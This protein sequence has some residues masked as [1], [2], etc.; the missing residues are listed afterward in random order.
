MNMN[1][2]QMLWGSCLCPLALSLAQAQ[3]PAP[4]QLPDI[5]VTGERISRHQ[6]DTSTSVDVFDWRR[7]R[8]GSNANMASDALK[9]TV[10]TVDI[11]TGN[12]LPTI[13]GID[14]S[15]PAQGAVAFLAGTRP[16]LSLSL[17]GRS[18][19]YN[20]FAFGSQSLWDIKQVEVFRGPQ[21][22]NQGKNAIAGAIFLTSNDPTDE[23]EGAVKFGMGNQSSSQT[24]AMISGPVVQDELS[25]RLSVDRQK[26]KS[27]V[28]LISYDPVGDP[29]R[30]ETT[31]TRAKLLFTPTA[32]PDFY[33][34]LTLNHI[35]ARAP[36]N[37]ALSNPIS[38]RYAAERPVFKTGSTSGIWD[39]S[40]R[41]NPLLWFENKLIYT[42]YD[43]DRLS[44]PAEVGGGPATVDGREL[45]IEPMLRF[46][47]QNQALKGMIGMHYFT[48]KQDEAVAL[49][50]GPMVFNNVFD[51]KTRTKAVLAEVTYAALPTLDVT[52]AGRLERETHQRHGGS[53]ALTMALDKTTT[54]F[55]P[56]LD[57]A[58]KPSEQ[59]ILGLRATRGYNPGGAGL[60]FAQ[61]IVSYAYEAEYVWNYELYHRYR[62][63]GR[64]FELSSNLFYNDYKDMQLP[65][66]L[67]A[68]SVAIRN[69]DKVETYGAELTG[70]WQATT[71]LRLMASLGLLKTEIKRYANQDIEGKALSRAP[72]VTMNT[73][74]AY[75]FGNGWDVAGDL[76]LVG[77]YYSDY[78]NNPVG[79]IGTY[80]QMNLTGG[81]HFKSGRIALYAD[82]VFDSG[83]PIFMPVLTRAEAQVQRPRAVGVTAEYWF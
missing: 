74:L 72:N 34:R 46:S 2:H 66:Y 35:K 49:R 27:F 39:V 64:R 22:L 37:E 15:G 33:S 57:V 53:R 1:K 45:Q 41:L 30:I 29:R 17:D 20:E 79:R 40:W 62:D 80:T 6:F 5:V 55:L 21:S 26:R 59:T 7:L 82:N 38:G 67:G 9:M 8:N 11:G 77:H 31:T 48:G 54:V 3:V 19:T 56:R 69:A 16:R 42:R 23:F 51:D 13:R 12:D 65:Y 14:G 36:Q 44:V 70:N 32:F 61:P 28:D 18:A 63:E 4:A 81:Y 60:T 47:S 83:K 52:L 76:R 24:A 10:N 25:F 50:F 73:G 43:N 78:H 58:W 71:Q 68:R 75:R